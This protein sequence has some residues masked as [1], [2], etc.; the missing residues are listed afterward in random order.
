MPKGDKYKSL[1][2]FLSQCES[3][4]VCLK[5]AELEKICGL[6]GS[7]YQYPAAWSNASLTSLSYGWLLADFIVEEYSLSEQW[8]LFHRNQKQAQNYLSRPKERKKDRRAYERYCR[9]HAALAELVDMPPLISAGNHFYDSLRT[10]THGRYRSWEYC[11]S[12]FS[13]YRE[14]C[15]SET[16]DYLA[17]HLAWYLASWGMLRGGAFLLQKDYKIHLPAVS[18]LLDPKWDALWSLSQSDL[19]K[20]D[21]AGPVIELSCELTNVYQREAGE[22]P[23]STL[24]TKILLGTIG[25]TPAYD[26]Y[27]KWTLRE[28]RAATAIFNEQSLRELGRL[29][30][31]QRDHFETLRYRF[32]SYGVLYPPM[33]VLD[34]CFFQYGLEHQEKAD[35]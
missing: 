1:T 8:V 19:I 13:S 27:L 12:V 18:L 16:L 33:K 28:T 31:V 9:T 4:T 34:M 23:S 22:T 25:C 20:G 15:D 35:L 7:A 26:R 6:P 3:E 5:F 32:S 17:L 30:A 10:D 14:A 21:F 11:Y 24:L 2:K 29:Y